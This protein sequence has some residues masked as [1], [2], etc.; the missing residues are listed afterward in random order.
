MGIFDFLSGQFIDVIHWVDNT[1][2]TMA[3]GTLRLSKPTMAA[4]P[5]SIQ[6][7][8]NREPSWP[9]HTAESR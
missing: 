5:P 7:H 9:P 6:P 8:S 4:Q 1:R 2:D 3:N